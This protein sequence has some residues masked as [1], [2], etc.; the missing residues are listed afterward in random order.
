MDKTHMYCTYI[1]SYNGTGKFTY[2]NLILM[3]DQFAR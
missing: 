1:D 3:I 2:K